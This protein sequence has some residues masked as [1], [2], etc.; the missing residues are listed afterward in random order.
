MQEFLWLARLMSH[1]NIYHRYPLCREPI[2]KLHR[3]TRIMFF[4]IFTTDRLHIEKQYLNFFCLCESCFEPNQSLDVCIAQIYEF[5][6]VVRVLFR[7]HIQY[8]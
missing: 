2:D 8:R 7:A 5:R 1:D 3:L 4:A 6:Q